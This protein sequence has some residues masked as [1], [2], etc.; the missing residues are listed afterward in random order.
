M[1]SEKGALARAARIEA[2]AGRLTRAQALLDRVASLYPRTDTIAHAVLLPSVRAQ[3]AL[4]VGNAATA[5]ED[6]KTASSYRGLLHQDV[7][8]LHA[9]ALLAAG[10]PAEALSEF[11]WLAGKAPSVEGG[12]LGVKGHVYSLSRLGIAR[13]A[14]RTGD[15]ETSRRAYEDFLAL[16]KDADPDVP[17]FVAAKQEYTRLVASYLGEDGR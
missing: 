8:Y 16:W 14:A 10:R 4:A 2:S 12:L 1:F 17:I 13:A 9:N 5:V 6:L 7:A 11:K 15:V 3:I